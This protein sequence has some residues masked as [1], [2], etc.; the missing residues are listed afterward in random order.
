MDG[1]KTMTFGPKLGLFAAD[2]TAGTADPSAHPRASTIATRTTTVLRIAGLLPLD[3]GP[4]G[5][6]YYTRTH[7]RLS[8]GTAR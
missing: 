2:A 3:N 6:P 7:L 1:S 8:L 5:R 4:G